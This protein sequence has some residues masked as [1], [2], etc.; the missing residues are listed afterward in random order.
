MIFELA[1]SEA[2][3]TEIETR[4]QI[5]LQGTS[6]PFTTA[7]IYRLISLGALPFHPHMLNTDGDDLFKT[8]TLTNISG[9][10]K[11]LDVCYLRRFSFT[12]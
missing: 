2:C 12:A 6:H 10:F 1:L 11:L 4:H 7:W 5:M 8:R 9:T 3:M